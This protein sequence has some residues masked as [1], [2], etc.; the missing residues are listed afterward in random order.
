MEKVKIVYVGVDVSKNT[1]DVCLPT[2]RVRGDETN[3]KSYDY[4]DFTNNIT[5]IKSFVGLLNGK[6]LNVVEPDKNEKKEWRVVM[7]NTG[8][9]HKILM[10]ELSLLNIKYSVINSKAS[11][12][13]HNVLGEKRK[14]TDKIDSYELTR[15]GIAKKPRENKWI[16]ENEQMKITRSIWRMA[17]KDLQKLKQNKDNIYFLVKKT[18]RK[19][20]EMKNEICKRIETYISKRQDSKALKKIVDNI[21]MFAETEEEQNLVVKMLEKN[22]IKGYNKIVENDLFIT[23]D[24]MI[25]EKETNI[26]ELEKILITGIKNV[27]ANEY[28]YM[29]SIPGVADTVCIEIIVG[30]NGMR[31]FENVKQLKSFI[32]VVPSGKDSG[33]SVNSAERISHMADKETR[34]AIVM[35]TWSATKYNEAVANKYNRLVKRKNKP[36]LAIIACANKLV[37]QIYYCVKKQEMFKQESEI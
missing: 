1:F 8:V 25:T 15:F 7:E 20:K 34:K 22:L 27:Y 17:K 10:R 14:R 6:R 24:R 4:K 16:V 2:K 29:K 11:K 19:A 32:G 5:G 13:W 26:K 3:P 28:K 9:Y 36:K 37:T 31:N 12:A 30:T 18:D 21:E 33:T 35:G 23:F